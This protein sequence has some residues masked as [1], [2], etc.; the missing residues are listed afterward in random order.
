MISE[1]HTAAINREIDGMSTPEESAQLKDLLASNEEARA[2]Y[3]DLSR[4]STM[5]SSVDEVEPP[6]KLK[7]GVMSAIE[8]KKAA[9]APASTLRP[10]PA[11][12]K[13]SFLHTILHGYQ[14]RG[15]WA[16]AFSFAAFVAGIAIGFLG[17]TALGNGF[18]TSGDTSQFTGSMTPFKDFEIVD[19]KP[20]DENGVIGTVETRYTS[21]QIFT[22]IEVSS[23][24]NL[25]IVVEFD[26]NLL[27]PIGF[28]QEFPTPSG[29]TLGA[30]EMRLVHQGQNVYVLTLGYPAMSASEVHVKF[31]SGGLLFER[32]LNALPAGR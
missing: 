1:K 12:E 31:Y 28:H 20:L 16:Y 19:T 27:S 23:E 25:D 13:V 7:S 3:E 11:P 15:E 2:Y 24:Q 29:I 6:A 17:F 22:K 4:L 18:T 26:G 9:Q 32:T 8:M 21:N 5:L 10:V 14:R 30:N